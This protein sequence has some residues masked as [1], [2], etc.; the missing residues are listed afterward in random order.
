MLSMFLPSMLDAGQ[1]EAIR[2]AQRSLLQLLCWGPI[3]ETAALISAAYVLHRLNDGRVGER[4][5]STLIIGVS[6]CA[7]HCMQYGSAAVASLPMALTLAHAATRAVVQLPGVTLV[8]ALAL[9]AMHAVYNAGLLGI[10]VAI[11]AA[12]A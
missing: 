6:F 9:A 12:H 8:S 2:R 7:T 5:V 10:E 1:D 11:G 4:E 3:F